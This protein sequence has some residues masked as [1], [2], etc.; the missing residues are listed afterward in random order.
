MGLPFAASQWVELNLVSMPA[1]HDYEISNSLGNALQKLVSTCL[2]SK[3]A[4]V[5][6]MNVKLYLLLQGKNSWD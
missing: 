1:A 3:T 2:L 4:K 5:Y 6:Y